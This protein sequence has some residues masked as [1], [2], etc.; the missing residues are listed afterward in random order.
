ME[1]VITSPATKAHME[2][3]KRWEDKAYDKF[4]VR[5][6]KGKKEVIAEHAQ[7]KGESLN[8]FVNR[9]IDN[10]MQ[11]DKEGDGD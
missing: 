9:A 1:V 7:S 6:T 10:Q 5:T 3:T 11:R 2:A 4:L 8:S